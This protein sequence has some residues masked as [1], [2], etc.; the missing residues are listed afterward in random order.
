VLERRGKRKAPTTTS[1]G[2][3]SRTLPRPL[4]RGTSNVNVRRA[5][6]TSAGNH[7]RRVAVPVELNFTLL[8][9]PA[10]PR[11]A[12]SD[13]DER[14]YPSRDIILPRPRSSRPTGAVLFSSNVR[15]L[16]RQPPRPNHSRP[17][18]TLLRPTPAVFNPSVHDQD[19]P[20]PNKES[21][22]SLAGMDVGG[23]EDFGA[24]RTDHAVDSGEKGG[25]DGGREG[26]TPSKSSPSM[27]EINTLLRHPAL[28][29]PVLKPRFPIVLCHGKLASSLL[30]EESRAHV[31]CYRTLR[32]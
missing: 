11:S 20:K 8:Q 4:G 29:D 7:S 16:P 18:S 27:D 15:I 2:L 17:L 3:P 32:L 14:R 6:A 31:P 23:R 22:A 19:R 30:G 5:T 28:Y 26:W 24:S 9:A 13:S 25:Q 21:S 10:S 1:D 12:L